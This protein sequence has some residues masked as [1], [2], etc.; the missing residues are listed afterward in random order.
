MFI[1]IDAICEIRR[2]LKL[3]S[4]KIISFL[5]KGIQMAMLVILSSSIAACSGVPLV[6]GI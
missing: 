2:V 6:P 3:K 5:N 4:I 1:V